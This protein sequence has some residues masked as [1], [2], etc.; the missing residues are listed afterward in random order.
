MA[1]KR[2]VAVPR[3]V[4]ETLILS[5]GET[6]EIRFTHDL[7]SGQKVRPIGPFAEAL[8]VLDRL[9]DAGRIEVLLDIWAAAFA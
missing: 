2:P 9:D 5:S 7:Q 3:G 6:G 4:V 1:Q 8:G